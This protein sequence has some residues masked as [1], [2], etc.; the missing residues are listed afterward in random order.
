MTVGAKKS[1]CSCLAPKTNFVKITNAL[2]TQKKLKQTQEFFCL[3]FS[4][5]EAILKSLQEVAGGG[6]NRNVSGK[7][8]SLTNFQ[9]GQQR[10]PNLEV[11]LK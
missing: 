10:N 3:R 5:Q 8:H 1:C 4:R 2:K 6:D 11:D 7:L 9:I